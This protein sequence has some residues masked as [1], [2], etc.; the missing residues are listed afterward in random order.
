MNYAGYDHPIYKKYFGNL[1]NIRFVPQS[2]H[3]QKLERV[4]VQYPLAKLIALGELVKLYGFE[5]CSRGDVLV[6]CNLRINVSCKEGNPVRKW[7][8]KN[9]DIIAL[10]LSGQINVFE[11]KRECS[12]KLDEIERMAKT[13][14]TLSDLA[15][16]YTVCGAGVSSW[17]KW[18]IL[19]KNCFEKELRFPALSNTLEERFS[20]KTDQGKQKWADSIMEYIRSNKYKY[21]IAFSGAARREK[22]K[23]MMILLEEKV[24]AYEPAFNNVRKK[25]F[26]ISLLNGKIT[27]LRPVG[28]YLD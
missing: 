1:K 16:P 7:T 27:D 23:E 25:I 26:I 21:I 12:F 15:A 24:F 20:L 14:I 5:S 13:L 28:D 8:K 2:S 19:Y 11:C 22:I 6:L 18:A 17:S 3:D 4:K 10:T 9:P